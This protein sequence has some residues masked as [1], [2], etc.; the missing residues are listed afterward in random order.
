MNCPGGFSEKDFYLAEFR[1]RALAIAVSAAEIGELDSLELVLAEL[2]ANVTR[3]I[4]LSPDRALL[5]KLTTQTPLATSDSRWVGSLWRGLRRRARMGISVRPDEAFAGACREI[6]LRL[7]LAKL[8][9]IDPEAWLARPDGNRLSFADLAQL[10]LLMEAERQR[11]GEA[12]A[13]FCL[14]R[15]IRAMVAGGIPSVNFCNLAGL[16][17]ELFSY[18]GAGT[19]FARDGYADVRRLALDEYEAAHHLIQRGVSE[20]YLVAR[21]EE[22]LEQVLA[23]AFGVFIEG[24]YLAGIGALLPHQRSLAGEVVSLYTLTRFLGE[25]VGTHLVDFAADIARSSGLT[26]L[27]AC[28]TSE[29]VERFFERCGFRPV[30]R[31]R[32]PSGKW[33]DYPPER[34]E[35]VRCLRRELC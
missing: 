6:A 34:L 31:S 20:G 5:E 33:T 1:G 12:S 25:G 30:D 24:R 26:Y 2:E 16:A 27:F 8:V 4:L 32:V 15:E 13:R 28:T 22:D 23:N 11:G 9:W 35:R 21:S 17:D 10:D 7:R 14:L 18:A 29:R 3:V 19:F